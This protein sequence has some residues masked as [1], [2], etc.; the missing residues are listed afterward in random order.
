M[1]KKA[2]YVVR[3]VS[4]RGVGF[5]FRYF[6][7]SYLFDLK[8]GTKTSSRVTK[9]DQNIS[10]TKCEQENGLLYV[11]SFTSVTRDTVSLAK[12]ILGVERFRKSQF[13]D[14]GCGKG[15]AL[16]VHALYFGKDH[17][18]PGVGIEYDADL[19]ITA[20]D[21]VKKCGIPEDRVKV[22]TDS[23][24]NLK[25]HVCSKELVVYLYNSFQGE[26]LKSVLAELSTVPHVLIYVDPAEQLLLPKYGYS[27]NYE[28]TGKYHADTWLV[29]SA[30]L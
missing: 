17:D 27:V 13:I 7:E 30:N 25:Q 20:R 14:L 12:T 1:I 29:A 28:Q 26:T 2:L 18:K 15:K 22:V 23:A 5:L 19:A 4:Q 3:V 9:D 6:F 21:N 8:N 24:V 10:S 11:A 16:L